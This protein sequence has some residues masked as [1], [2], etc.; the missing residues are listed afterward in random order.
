VPFCCS[1]LFCSAYLTAVHSLLHVGSEVRL[2]LAKKGKFHFMSWREKQEII[3]SSLERWLWGSVDD[4]A[5]AIWVP[6]DDYY[7]ALEEDLSQEQVL[8]PKETATSKGKAVKGK[9]KAAP[10][11][12]ARKKTPA[13]LPE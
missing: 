1:V 2:Q 9:A 8:P 7:E 4:E 3:D 6:F 13:L 12:P 11:K 10:A 5:G